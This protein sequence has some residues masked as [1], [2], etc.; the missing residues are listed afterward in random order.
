MIIFISWEHLCATVTLQAPNAQKTVDDLYYFFWKGYDA[1]QHP[2][3]FELETIFVQE[4][5]DISVEVT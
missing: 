5:I 1:M 3:K 2:A 4:T